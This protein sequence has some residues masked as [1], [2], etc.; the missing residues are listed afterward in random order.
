[1][2]MNHLIIS[3]ASLSLLLAATAAAAG[4]YKWVDDQGRVHYSQSPPMDRGSENIK[5]E[6]APKSSGKTNTKEKTQDNEQEATAKTPEQE[7]KYKVES[8]ASIKRN[9]E[10]AQNKLKTFNSRGQIQVKEGKGYRMLSEKER[11]AGIAEA[12]KNIKEYCK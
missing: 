5:A 11:T 1:M 4:M 10:R 2:K 12:R 3:V 7:E 8:D 9:C 6:P